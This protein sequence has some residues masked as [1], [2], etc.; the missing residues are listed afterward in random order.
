MGLLVAEVSG[1]HVVMKTAHLGRRLGDWLGIVPEDEIEWS[2]PA[3]LFGP[4]AVARETRRADVEM[5]V[6]AT[7]VEATASPTLPA[8]PT[9]LP[10][11]MPDSPAPS[12]VRLGG[13]IPEPAKNV[14]T[15]RD[16]VN[17]RRADAQRRAVNPQAP[18]RW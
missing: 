14:L 13:P 16:A 11:R 17:R 3:D 9:A 6:L 18:T 12:P 5:L 8:P 1:H 2:T 15:F 10:T 4:D 7:P